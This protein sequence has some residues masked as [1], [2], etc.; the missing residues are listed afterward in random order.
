MFAQAALVAAIAFVVA[1]IVLSVRHS[2]QQQH[3][4]NHQTSAE[5]SHEKPDNTA[6][7]ESAE[8]VIARYTFWLMVF[9]GILAFVAM[10]QI[11]FLISADKTAARSS[12][13]TEKAANI[14]HDALVT[15]NRAF[16]I[17]DAIGFLWHTDDKGANIWWEIA[18]GWL[19]AGNTRTNGLT[20]N[21]NSYFEDAALPDNWSFPPYPGPSTTFFLGP[22]QSTRGDPIIKTGAELRAVKSG[23]KHLYIWGSARYKDIFTG[24]PEHV[25]RVAWHIFIFGD[26]T[27]PAN[28][29]NV[30]R[31]VGK[32]PPK[33]NCVD[34]ECENQGYGPNK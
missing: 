28:A 10:I 27:R 3:Q 30:V 14:A 16:V 11:Y 5:E 22:K 21:V 7:T 15:G 9:T 6:T 17:P 19:N 8:D 25:T 20:V 4:A 13:A 31:V 26:P 34:D 2:Y 29:R 23:T 12:R 24:T 32:L 33:H 1:M 18:P